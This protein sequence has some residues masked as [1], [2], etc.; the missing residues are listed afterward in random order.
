MRG[1]VDACTLC[2]RRLASLDILRSAGLSNDSTHGTSGN[3]PSSGASVST[4][5]QPSAAHPA[6]AGQESG[7]F[8]AWAGDTATTQA[9]R[10]QAVAQQVA[11]PPPEQPVAQVAVPPPEHEPPAPRQMPVPPV[12]QQ[13][14]QQLA[15][16]PPQQQQLAVPPQP[17][18]QQQPAQLVVPPQPQQLPS[19]L[20]R[21]LSAPANAWGITAPVQQPTLP[22]V[23]P[24]W[25]LGGAT[26][27]WGPM[28]AL[29][30]QGQL[31]GMP[32][33]RP[34]TTM[35]GP[36]AH[37]S[38]PASAPTLAPTTLPPL[39]DWQNKTWGESS[40]MACLDL[41]RTAPAWEPATSAA[42]QA[43]AAA[44]AAAAAAI[45]AAASGFNVP[46][47]RSA[48]GA[49]AEPSRVFLDR[50]DLAA[51]EAQHALFSDEMWDDLLS[52]LDE[53]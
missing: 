18:Q 31:A 29:Q 36:S 46:Q 9:Q 49:A 22:I 17:Q 33:A 5:S 37:T 38:A 41:S 23:Q 43:T 13:Q 53:Q 15:V 34:R 2:L 45:A 1:F 24:V 10:Q 6:G 26:P 8:S 50:S 19:A 7:S 40:H 51:I 14:Q 47:Q 3:R 16:P 27:N 52:A 21:V 39:P 25:Q 4:P 44:A 30:Q 32:P 35:C 11:V 42:H 48:L 20:P 12:Q 28:A